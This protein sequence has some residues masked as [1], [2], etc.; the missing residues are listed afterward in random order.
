MLRLSSYL[1]HMHDFGFYSQFRHF[2]IVL[3]KKLPLK[4]DYPTEKPHFQHLCIKLINLSLVLQNFTHSYQ[5]CR[6]RALLAFASYPRRREFKSHRRQN[7]M[8]I[9]CK[10]NGALQHCLMELSKGCVNYVPSC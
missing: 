7:F 10:Q 8:C 5:I 3:S 9:I 2:Q 6:S 1:D 4:A